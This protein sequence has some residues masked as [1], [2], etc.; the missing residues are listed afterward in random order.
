[1]IE[2]SVDKAAINVRKIIANKHTLTAME[3]HHHS[4]TNNITLANNRAATY[5]T[6]ILE[7]NQGHANDQR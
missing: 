2:F 7:V 1:M 3:Q 4:L 5:E 6:V